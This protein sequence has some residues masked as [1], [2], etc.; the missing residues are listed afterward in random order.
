MS[1][2]LAPHKEQ[3]GWVY[4]RVLRIS[5][6]VQD[7]AHNVYGDGP[8]RGVP[9]YATFLH[10]SRKWFGIQPADD[11]PELRVIS[12]RRVEE[13]VETADYLKRCA[14]EDLEVRFWSAVFETEDG[15]TDS[16]SPTGVW[17]QVFRPRDKKA[18]PN[19]CY[20]LREAYWRYR[21]YASR[22]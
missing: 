2:I 8:E 1:K 13:A 21:Q 12:S 20:T 15:S 11:L 19:A 10:V 5:Q 22:E 16:I 17:W 6:Q 18:Q 7:R 14:E 4:L 9:A 3:D